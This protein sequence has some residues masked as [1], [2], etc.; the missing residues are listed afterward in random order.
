MLSVE[1]SNLQAMI[2]HGLESDGELKGHWRLSGLAAV[3]DSE[4]VTFQSK[5]Y[6]KLI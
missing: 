5:V 1:E 2:A 6:V 3:P 4:V